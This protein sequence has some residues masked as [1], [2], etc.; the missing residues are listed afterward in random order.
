MK[1]YQPV[2]K[3]ANSHHA[4]EVAINKAGQ[5]WRWGDLSASLSKKQY[6][7]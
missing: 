6:E 7:E 1:K 2:S 4:L 3:A 5:V